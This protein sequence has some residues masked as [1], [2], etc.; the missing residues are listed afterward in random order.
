[1]PSPTSYAAGLADLELLAELRDLR[2]NDGR[3]L[4]GIKL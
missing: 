3:D 4:A 1:M 2:P